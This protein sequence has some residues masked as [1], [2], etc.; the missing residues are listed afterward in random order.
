MNFEVWQEE[1][2]W[3]R[4]GKIAY[5]PVRSPLCPV[6]TASALGPLDDHH[7]HDVAI[8]HEMPDNAQQANA[9]SVCFLNA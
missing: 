1:T 3:G 7:E 8:C 2:V 5:V 6:D 9:Q 4:I